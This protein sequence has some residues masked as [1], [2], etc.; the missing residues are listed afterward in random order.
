LAEPFV[1]HLRDW[2]V[3][4]RFQPA[5]EFMS[6]YADWL[7]ILKQLFMAGNYLEIFGF[8]QWVLRHH[9]KPHRLEIN[10]EE[11]FRASRAA[12]ALFDNDTIMPIGSDAERETSP[13]LS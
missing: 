9:A 10:V 5:D 12:Y 13:G 8:V 4:R 6:S 1:V 11:A 3:N 7:P 2:Y